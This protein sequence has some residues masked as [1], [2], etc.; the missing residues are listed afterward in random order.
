MAPRQRQAAR[1]KQGRPPL[2]DVSAN[3]TA[4]ADRQP[5]ADVNVNTAAAA[6]KAVEHA[7][8]V[9]SAEKYFDEAVEEEVEKLISAKEKLF[10]NSKMALRAR[11][12]ALPN[13]LKKISAAEF[14]ADY[15]GDINA[16][17]LCEKQGAPARE[18][19]YQPC[20]KLLAPSNPAP[21]CC[22]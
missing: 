13:R 14:L 7:R 17:L 3:S 16:F 1:K 4:P 15:G 2:A 12:L 8:T 19:N 9:E 20:L 10:A 21:S 22:A 6:A 5:L 11:L 18:A